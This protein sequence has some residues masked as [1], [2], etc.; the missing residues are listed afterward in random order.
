VAIRRRIDDG[1]KADVA[2]GFRPVLDNDR[3]A[4]PLGK[5][6]C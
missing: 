3:L 4:E 5:R 2:A 6:L 1:F